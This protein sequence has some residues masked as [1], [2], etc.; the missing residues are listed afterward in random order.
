MNDMSQPDQYADD[1][2]ITGNQN[3]A[4]QRVHVASLCHFDGASNVL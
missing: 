2:D 3:G 4:G 1:S